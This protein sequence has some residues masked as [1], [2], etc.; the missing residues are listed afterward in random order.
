MLTHR[1]RRN[2]TTLLPPSNAARHDHI[3]TPILPQIRHPNPHRIQ[4]PLRI[5]IQLDHVR[6]RAPIRV[7]RKHILVPTDT[8]IRA[9]NV[10]AAKEALR[11]LKERELLRVRARVAVAVVDGR[12]VDFLHDGGRDGVVD[13]AKEDFGAVTCKGMVSLVSG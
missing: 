5:D 2:R 3:P 4:T 9:H 13:V 10:H 11:L 6:L 12:V 7:R 8:G 1:I